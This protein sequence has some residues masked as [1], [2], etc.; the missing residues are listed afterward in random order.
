MAA[1]TR[2]NLNSKQLAS[3]LA[4]F[5]FAT[6]CF[7]QRDYT[8]ANMSLWTKMLSSQ[9]DNDNQIFNESLPA[10]MREDS[11]TTFKL[12]SSLQSNI[13]SANQYYKARVDCF[14]AWVHYSYKTYSKVSDITALTIK[15]INDAYETDDQLLLAFINWSCGSI[16]INSR[17]LESAVTYKLKAEEIYDRLG[18]PPY[19]DSIGN[20]AVLGEL[21]FHT[22][23]FDQ[24]IY[25]TKR[26]LKLWNEKTFDS[27]RLRTRYYNT[28]A[29]AYDQIG[30]S[31]SALLYLDSSLALAQRTKNGVWT[32]I[33]SGV[34]GQ[35]LFKMKQYEK[36]KP[37]LETD[38]TINRYVEQDVAARSLQFLARI[39]LAQH[40][41]DSALL[42]A[43]DAFALISKADFKHYLQPSRVLEM[44][45][46]TLSEAFK[47]VGNTDSFYF[48][49]Q[50]YQHLHDSIQMIT[51]ESSMRMVQTKIESENIQQAVHHLQKERR[52]EATKRNLIIVGI[53]AVALILILY[54]NRLKMKQ[55][56][57][58][59]I[60]LKEKR[61]AETELATAKE[62]MHNFTG[63]IIE[64][65][66]LIEKLSE[67]L[68]HRRID[69]HKQQPIIEELTNQTI[70]TEE[71]WE[72]FKKNFEKIYPTF[73]K[74]LKEKAPNI[75][76]AEQRMAALIRLSLSSKQM[77][78]TLGISIDSVHKSKQRLRQRMHVHDGTD[79]EST[80][81]YL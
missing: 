27:E 24:S 33:S 10:L 9:N 55:R 31:D 74:S 63:N 78:S 52:N 68:A 16:M 36:A 60:V 46:F 73:F 34:K 43:K 13:P 41:Y 32:G 67:Q 11:S 44:C 65:S 23:D 69:P 54:L 58:E 15:A 7:S 49:N 79:L 20:W 22:G 5:L 47:A 81:S 8:T 66:A 3:M 53:T 42:K 62:Q 45:Y 2:L 19:Y 26:A 50:Q 48:Y 30:Q 77:A 59:E 51:Y 6:N 28:I 64:K 37:L 35:V 80:L 14:S 61:I 40:K 4:F 39:D 29:Q 76:V 71:D 38:Y 56:H 21:L 12:L 70:L 25:Y 57:R 1:L 72:H 75:T 18:H 17:Q